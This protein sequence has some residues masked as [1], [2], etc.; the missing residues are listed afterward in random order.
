MR[1][2]TFF[3]HFI[4][5]VA[6][7]LSAFLLRSYLESLLTLYLFN[8]INISLDNAYITMSSIYITVSIKSTYNEH[9]GSIKLVLLLE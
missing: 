2:R 7:H 8:N 3:Y 4:P 1:V 9:T 5:A 6:N